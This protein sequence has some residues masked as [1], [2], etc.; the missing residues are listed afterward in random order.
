M[1]YRIEY[2]STLSFG[3]PVHEQACELRL[4]PREEG[5]QKV[6]SFQ[7]DL[8]PVTELFSYTDAYANRVHYFTV[9]PA[10]DS[11]EVRFTAEVENHLTNPFDYLPPSPEQER[12]SLDLMLGE[13]P[14]LNDFVLSVSDTVPSL[15]SFPKK[16]DWPAWDPRK[17]LM[18][19]GQ[20]A[21]AWIAQHF[22][23]LPGSTDVHFPFREFFEKKA[24]VCQDFAHL[25]VAIFRSWGVP[26]RYVM[27]YQYLDAADLDGAKPA[28]H[29]WTEAFL[30]GRGWQGFDAT[31]QLLANE[32]YLPVAVGRDSR[33]AAPQRG[34]YKGGV[35]GSE[36]QVELRVVDQQ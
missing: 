14:R 12:R 9:V 36:P 23:Y 15:A 30:P 10:H 18:Q 13:Q 6:R 11:L 28:T 1:H 4:L 3:A 29:A 22:L 26:A 7:L 24:G 27:G 35:V 17:N 21:M 16:V 20:E 34:C 32:T 33:D 8:Q 31:Q 2:T 5:Y 25:L 19:A